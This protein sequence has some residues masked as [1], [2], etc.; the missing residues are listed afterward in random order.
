M[1]KSPGRRGQVP[2]MHASPSSGLAGM[3]WM[4]TCIPDLSP[5]GGLWTKG[6]EC[7]PR[8][9]SLPAIAREE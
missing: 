4:D 8:V 9:T 3:G 2:R 1:E 7:K 5:R 6:A